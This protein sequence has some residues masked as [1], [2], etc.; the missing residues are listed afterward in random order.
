LGSCSAHS[1]TGARGGNLARLFE[2]D[3][4]CPHPLSEK[5]V[6]HYI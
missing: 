5:L 1:E 4:P 3:R 6:H 2:A